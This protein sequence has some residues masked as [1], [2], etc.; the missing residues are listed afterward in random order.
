MCQCHE[1][2][3][4]TAK[5]VTLKTNLGRCLGPMKSMIR[6]AY[7]CVRYFLCIIV[8]VIAIEILLDKFYKTLFC[9]CHGNAL[10]L[11]HGFQN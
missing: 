8:L 7:I 10:N 4:I 9:S 3:F 2:D 1:R 5:C 11:G 6:Y